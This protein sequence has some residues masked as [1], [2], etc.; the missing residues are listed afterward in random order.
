M[1][2]DDSLIGFCMCSV[3]VQVLV[4]NLNSWSH[5]HKLLSSYIHI[6]ILYTLDYTLHTLKYIIEVHDIPIAAAAAGA[7]DCSI[8]QVQPASGQL[9][10]STHRQLKSISAPKVNV[11]LWSWRGG[12][13]I[14]GPGMTLTKSIRSSSITKKQC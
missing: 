8:F 13:T 1:T 12:E 5:Y 11:P 4:M 3:Q 6:H 14:N 2:F 10:S 9:N 7:T